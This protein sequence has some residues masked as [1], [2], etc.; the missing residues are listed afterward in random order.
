MAQMGSAEI[1]RIV[2]ELETPIPRQFTPL[3]R[4]LYSKNSS[5]TPHR[6]VLL[7]KSVQYDVPIDKETQCRP[8]RGFARESWD[9]G[10][11]PV[12]RNL[13]LQPIPNRNKIQIRPGNR[14]RLITEIDYDRIARKIQKQVRKWMEKIKKGREIRAIGRVQ[15]WWKM[16]L[17]KRLFKGIK[18]K[19]LKIQ[20]VFRGFRV[21]KLY[22]F[23]LNDNFDP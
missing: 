5:P 11:E 19:I 2:L 20:K 7:S 17:M 8:E 10:K 12:N 15:A 1:S 13:V 6:P 14:Y 21:R 4:Y 3:P 9:I 18:G 23:L 22:K 16:F